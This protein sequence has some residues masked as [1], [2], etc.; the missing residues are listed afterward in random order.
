MAVRHGSLWSVWLLEEAWGHPSKQSCRHSL[1]P[2]HQTH[3]KPS[4]ISSSLRRHLSSS[5]MGKLRHTHKVKPLFWRPATGKGQNQNSDPCRL[6][7]MF[8]VPPWFL[9][10]PLWNGG[11]G[12]P[13]GVGSLCGQG[14]SAC[15]PSLPSSSTL[16][17]L[18]GHFIFS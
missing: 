7:T 9:P 11:W 4:P 14:A 12:I 15:T 16:D 17:C 1:H 3:A 18:M 13:A 10:L 8:A 6:A 5:Q 2:R